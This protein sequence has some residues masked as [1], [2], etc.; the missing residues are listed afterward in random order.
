MLFFCLLKGVE[1]LGTHT[2][3]YTPTQNCPQICIAAL[4]II[5]R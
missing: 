1:N 2:H 4:F 5:D 3:P